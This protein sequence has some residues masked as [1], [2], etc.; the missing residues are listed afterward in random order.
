MSAGFNRDV[1]DGKKP[2]AAPARGARTI[3]DFTLLEVGHSVWS[4][5]RKDHRDEPLGGVII[6][7]FD[8]RDPDTGFTERAFRCIDPFSLRP[9]V[10]V[11]VLV[12]SEVDR[13]A[14]EPADN[15][16]LRK[17]I[18]RLAEDIAKGKSSLTTAELDHIAWMHKLAGVVVPAA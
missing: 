17:I 9:F 14:L 10:Q 16:R 7:I 4:T 6:A 8:K 18:R 13:E 3:G 15:A 2:M 5:K 1:W 12:E 11:H